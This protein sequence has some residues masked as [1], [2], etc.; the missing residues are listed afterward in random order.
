MSPTKIRKKNTSSAAYTAGLNAFF[1]SYANEA[2]VR[3]NA[4]NISLM[5]PEKEAA[6]L[7]EYGI[8]KLQKCYATSTLPKGQKQI[9]LLCH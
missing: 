9:D 4:E 7:K 8:K 1:K 5:C 6:E 2:Q 3:T